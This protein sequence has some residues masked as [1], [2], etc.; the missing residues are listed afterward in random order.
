MATNSIHLGPTSQTKR[1]IP[2]EEIPQIPSLQ[3]EEREPTGKPAGHEQLYYRRD[4]PE[5]AQKHG[6]LRIISTGPL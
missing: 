6:V 3:E 1:Q 2:P 4:S 5:V